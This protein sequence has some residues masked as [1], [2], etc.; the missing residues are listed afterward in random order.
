MRIGKDIATTLRPGD[1]L[2]L[3]GP[4]GAGKTF[5]A[6]SIARALGLPGAERVTS[7]TFNLVT[8]HE[9]RRGR[10]LHVDLYRLRDHANRDAEVA[11]LEL[12]EARENGAIVLVEWGESFI[13]HV[14]ASDLSF[15]LEVETSESGSAQNGRVGILSPALASRLEAAS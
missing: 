12:R 15:S 6:R 3:S 14:G 13:A 10:V 2:Y 9:T 1:A 4:L 11:R 5:V 8:E 7:P